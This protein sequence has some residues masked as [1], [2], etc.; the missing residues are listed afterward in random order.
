LKLVL[1]ITAAARSASVGKESLARDRDAL[2]R[3]LVA[4]YGKW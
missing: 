3:S 4:R 1:V 2:W